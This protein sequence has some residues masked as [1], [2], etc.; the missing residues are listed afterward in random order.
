MPFSNPRS[1]AVSSACVASAGRAS[2]RT[3]A[4]RVMGASSFSCSAEAEAEASGGEGLWGGEGEEGA[5]G[6][7]VLFCF[8]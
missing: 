1:P 7:V 8:G 2:R 3:E 6:M 4:A 5:E